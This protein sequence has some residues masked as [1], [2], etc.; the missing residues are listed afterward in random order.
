[1]GEFK[2]TGINS[3]VKISGNIISLYVSL[4]TIQFYPE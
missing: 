4:S 1:L 3:D 2:V